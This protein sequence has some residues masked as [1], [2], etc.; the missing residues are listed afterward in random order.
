MRDPYE[1]LGVG[2]N[3]TDEEI[4]TAYRNLAKK[5]HPDKYA[6][7]D[8][9]DLANEK[10]QEI[11]QAYDEIT[12]QRSSGFGAQYGGQYEYGA[13]GSE[14][15]FAIR[16]M[17]ENG[18]LEEAYSNLNNVPLQNQNAEWH[19]LMGQYFYRKGMLSNALQYFGNACQL[20]PQNTEYRAAYSQLM[21]ST[22]GGYRTQNT[23]NNTEY[24]SDRQR[25]ASHGDCCDCDD[26][27]TCDGCDI[28][29]GLICA[30]CCCESMGGDLIPCC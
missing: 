19:F 15:F 27:C 30:D 14:E 29:S 28:C 18:Q 22:S 5:Y 2:R 17:L 20:D 11:N 23:Y 9:A 10:M 4:K 21:N 1:I 24:R 7:T 6:G 12:R 25:R 13:S 3:S 26:C 8:L 16:Q